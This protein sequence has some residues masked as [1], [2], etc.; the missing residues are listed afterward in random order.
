LQVGN[1]LGG[2]VITEYIYALP[3]V[4]NLVV[5]SIFARDFPLV[6]G[7]VLLTA[8][9]FLVVNFVVDVLYGYLDPRIRLS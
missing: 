4:G 5:D 3:G 2:A 1:L 6:Q 7:V 9:G 8:C